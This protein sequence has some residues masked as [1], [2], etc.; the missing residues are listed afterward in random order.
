MT[1]WYLGYVAVELLLAGLDTNE[2]LHGELL[3]AGFTNI[4][5][6]TKI[7]L[8]PCQSLEQPLKIP[9][10]LNLRMQPLILH[11]WEGTRHRSPPK[12]P[13]AVSLKKA[14][15]HPRKCDND[16]EETCFPEP[17]TA[18]LEHE[19]ALSIILQPT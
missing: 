10:W 2:Q 4:R 11:I 18:D 1:P 12:V 3:V 8:W 9:F 15:H 16:E 6:T 14:R 13:V 5:K 7:L 17:R 19:D